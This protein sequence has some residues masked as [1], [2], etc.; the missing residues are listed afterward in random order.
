M[1]RVKEKHYKIMQQ[2]SKT[3]LVGVR[4]QFIHHHRPGGPYGLQKAWGN[5]DPAPEQ[6]DQH[7]PALQE[8]QEGGGPGYLHP[9][10]HRDGVETTRL[11]IW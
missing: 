3:I 9:G 8:V 5:W 4:G 7:S 11:S 10:H 1:P 6:G 2:L